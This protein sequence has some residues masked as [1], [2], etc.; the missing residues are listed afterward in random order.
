M[1]QQEIDRLISDI[2]DYLNH[3]GEHD[4]PQKQSAENRKEME[5]EDAE[6]GL[7]ISAPSRKRMERFLKYSPF[8]SYAVEALTIALFTAGILVP[9]SSWPRTLM[10]LIGVLLFGVFTI[11]VL[12]SLHARIQLLVQIESNTH[13]IA[14][15]KEKIARAL[16]RIRIE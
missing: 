6:A 8:A 4:E 2:Q 10:F 9:F 5:Q 11:T 3:V 1:D 7:F 12:L 15:Q 13:R 14:M 16:E